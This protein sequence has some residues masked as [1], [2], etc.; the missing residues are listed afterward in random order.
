MAALRAAGISCRLTDTQ[1][2]EAMNPFAIDALVAWVCQSE[3]PVIAFSV[4]NDAIP[5]VIATLDA[6][7]HKLSE[8]RIFVGGPGVVGIARRLLERVPSVETVIVGEGE[9]AFPLA[10]ADPDS[11]KSLSGVFTRCCDGGLF[12]TGKTA[13]ED[14]DALTPI[15]WEWAAKKGYTAV[16]WSTMRG[17]PFDCQFCEITAFMGRRVTMRSIPRA[18]ADLQRAIHALERRTVAILDD[19]FT[20]NKH[21]LMDLC[22]E[23][24]RL[25][26]G[27]SFEIFSR[28]DTLD[29]DM[30]EALAEAGCVRVFFGVD[31]GDDEVLER[32]AKGLKVEDAERTIHLAARFFEVTASFIWGYPFES[33]DAFRKMLLLAQRLCTMEERFPIWPQ[34]HLLSPSAG[35]PLFEQFNS[36]LTL[37]LNVET[38]PLGSTLST[39]S[40]QSNYSKVRE[41]IAADPLLAAPFYRYYTP[42]FPQ[43]W[44]D[45]QEFN[46]SLD[47]KVGNLVLRKLFPTQE[48]S[49]AS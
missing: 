10:I 38:L 35:T 41:I 24:H 18:L 37:D 46:R 5:L 4:F 36:T 43:K 7:K 13:R 44:A 8:R 26:L 49:C 3:A 29:V 12:G 15:A 25:Q 28:T 2:D 48:V 27:I 47:R 17:C 23:L 6:V 39:Q 32:V 21:R 11:A 40:F 31:G 20:V 33:M 19:T 30:M 9:T 34:L 16:P 42:G 1:F 22:R 14:L 45:I